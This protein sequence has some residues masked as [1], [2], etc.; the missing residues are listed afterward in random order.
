MQGIFLGHVPGLDQ[1]GGF[2]SYGWTQ[3]IV[4]QVMPFTRSGSCG[5]WEGMVIFVPPMDKG[6]F[7]I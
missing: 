7:A 3:G 6:S 4:C 2:L 5:K 1:E